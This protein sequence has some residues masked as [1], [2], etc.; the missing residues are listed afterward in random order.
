MA[1]EKVQLPVELELLGIRTHVTVGNA[2][3]NGEW[4]QEDNHCVFLRDPRTDRVY[5]IIGTNEFSDCPSGYTT[6]TRGYLGELELLPPGARIGSLH[7]VPLRRGTLCRIVRGYETGGIRLLGDSNRT[8]FLSYDENGDDHYYPC[9]RCWLDTNL[10]KT[11]G[12]APAKRPVW[13]LYSDRQKPDEGPCRWLKEWSSWFEHSSSHDA[14]MQ[15]Q[16]V[17][18][19]E[20]PTVAFV[21]RLSR[22]TDVSIT[23]SNVFVVHHRDSVGALEDL[24]LDSSSDPKVDDPRVVVHVR[25][26]SSHHDGEMQKTYILFGASS[27]G[28]SFL[29]GSLEHPQCTVFE[30]DSLRDNQPLPDLRAFRV[31]VLGNKHARHRRQ[32]DQ[33][34]HTHDHVRVSLFSR[35]SCKARIWSWYQ[36]RR[37][38]RLHRLLLSHLPRVIVNLVQEQLGYKLEQ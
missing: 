17:R 34:M 18:R 2:P 27:L 16:Q 35:E 28:K 9:G 11:T 12:R 38:A 32:I 21:D 30:T 29:A 8:E 13:L 4:Q 31:V 3:D 19:L 15:Q 23:K 33:W 5:S 24:L 22:V 7:Y 14:Q 37:R 36:R 26:S 1:E 6:C 10:L 20:R 25:F